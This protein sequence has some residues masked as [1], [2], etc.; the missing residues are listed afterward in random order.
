MESERIQGWKVYTKSHDKR[1]WYTKT[2]TEQIRIT[3]SNVTEYA[4]QTGAVK[5]LPGYSNQIY[6][7]A[8]GV[9]C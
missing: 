6:I 2:Y 4:E 7:I 1:E 9:L 5:V 8:A 3:A